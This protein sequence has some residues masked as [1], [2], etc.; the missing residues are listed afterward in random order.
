MSSGLLTPDERADV[1]K[2]LIAEVRAEHAALAA[3]PRRDFF[4]VDQVKHHI[5]EILHDNW[6]DDGVLF[7]E[8]GAV[9]KLT[10]FVLAF[11]MIEE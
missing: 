9:D 5:R 11:A 7:Y 8:E 3:A 10:E 1:A 4:S 2:R 6:L